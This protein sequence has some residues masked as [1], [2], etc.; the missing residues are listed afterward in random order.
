M[1]EKL[2]AIT[3]MA[4]GS[5][6]VTGEYPGWK[7]R[8]DSPLRGK[9]VALYEKMYG[10]KP[11]VEAIHAGLEC[12]ILGSKITDLDCVSLG[13]QMS[14]IH[15]TEETLSISSTARVYEFLVK[16]LEEKDN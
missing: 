15:T 1:I 5:V 7:Y 2:S 6:S 11:R 4:G 3:M 14:D 9:M 12:G 16:L 10:E 13:P 8:V